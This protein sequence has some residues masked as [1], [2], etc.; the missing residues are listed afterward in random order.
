MTGC[1][2][3]HGQHASGDLGRL[4][5]L[6]RLPEQIG[7]VHQTR[8]RIGR[9]GRVRRL[10][11]PIQHL[12]LRPRPPLDVRVEQHRGKARRRKRGR[13]VLLQQVDHLIDGE[14]VPIRRAFPQQIGATVDRL[15]QSGERDQR[16]HVARVPVAGGFGIGFSTTTGATGA[17]AACDLRSAL[18]T[19][20][21][22]FDLDESSTKR[23]ITSSTASRIVLI[24]ERRFS[25]SGGNSRSKSMPR[26][27]S[28][29]ETMR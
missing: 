27:I 12:S 14:G 2:A 26:D 10:H 11:H 16:L 4:A 20:S 7:G 23:Y 15:L 8:R 25:V 28:C 18:L 19:R 22:S 9:Q 1:V 6:L 5:P 21:A 29:I 3:Y 13:A 24:A 17:G